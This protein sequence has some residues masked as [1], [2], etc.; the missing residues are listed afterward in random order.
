[1]VAKKDVQV[2]M[3]VTCMQAETVY[4]NSHIRDLLGH[5]VLFEPGMIGTVARV[6]VPAVTGKE[7]SFCCIDFVH[8]TVT[9]AGVCTNGT[10]MFRVGLWYPNI[11]IIQKE[12]TT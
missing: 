10:N 11:R 3:H 2:G 8:P 5:S 12:G 9:L 7:R 6:D 4:N 1:M